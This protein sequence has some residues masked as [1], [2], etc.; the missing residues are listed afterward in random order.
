MLQ[1]RHDIDAHT[2]TTAALQA[3]QQL[4]SHP[5]F[6]QSQH[7][8]C[9]LARDDEFDCTPIIEAI[10]QAQK[11][12]YLPVISCNHVK[13]LEFVCYE[14]NAQLQ[15]NRYQI[16]EPVD[17]TQKIAPSK[18]D[19]VIV[20]LLAFDQQGNRLGMGSGYYDKTFAFSCSDGK[21]KLLGLGY[22]M[23]MVDVLPVE[24]W[25]IKLDGVLTEHGWW[26]TAKKT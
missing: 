7:V 1:K 16:Y 17:Q 8:A 25:D 10:W 19:L 14:K 21:P 3:M 18:L 26:L 2:R 23:Q 5:W 9:Y 20:P 22:Q 12:C 6:M 15:L 24:N 11:K 4:Q 13:T